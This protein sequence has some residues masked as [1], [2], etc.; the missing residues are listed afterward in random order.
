[1]NFRFAMYVCVMNLNDFNL[2]FI[3][4]IEIMLYNIPAEV[5]EESK[6]AEPVEPEAA[7]PIEPVAVDEPKAAEPVEPV[8]DEPAAPLAEVPY[9]NCGITFHSLS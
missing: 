4:N 2:N 8:V 9:Q 5:G 7:E 6:T 1:M 3:Q